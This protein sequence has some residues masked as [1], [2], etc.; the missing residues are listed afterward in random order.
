MVNHGERLDRVFQALADA[1]RREMVERLVRGP[2]AVSEI[3]RPFPMSLPAVMQHLQVLEASGPGRAEQVGRVRPC[4][5]E[6][7]AL[8][9]AEDWI[10]QRLNAPEQRLD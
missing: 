8:R 6:A 4:H 2:A 3:A 7:S 9:M 1:T 10:R 5:I